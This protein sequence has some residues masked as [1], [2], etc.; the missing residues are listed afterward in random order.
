MLDDDDIQKKLELKARLQQKRI[1]DDF[2]WLMQ[3]PQG[4]RHVWGQMSRA[5]IFQSTFDTHGGR[6]SLNEGMRQHGLYLLGEI[7]RLC[8]DLYPVMVRENSPQQET[9]NDD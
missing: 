5:K 3:A 8:P 9:Q 1:D 6:M 7:N 2:L 4:R